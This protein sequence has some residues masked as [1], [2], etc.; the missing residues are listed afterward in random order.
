MFYISYIKR[1]F[2]I[3]FRYLLMNAK[4]RAIR[5]SRH[6]IALSPVKSKFHYITSLSFI[7]CFKCA[8]DLFLSYESPPLI[9]CI[10]VNS[11]RDCM[12]MDSI[13]TDFYL[14]IYWINSVFKTMIMFFSN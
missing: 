1:I 14:F 10:Y 13:D 11:F 4:K 6:Q 8:M 12:M 9:T 3:R 7:F 5:L 2:A